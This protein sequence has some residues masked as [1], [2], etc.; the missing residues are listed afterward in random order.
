LLDVSTT[1]SL[2]VDSNGI[3]KGNTGICRDIT[4][5]KKA[6]GTLKAK[7][8][9][10][11]SFVESNPDAILVFDLQG[12]VIR[13]NKAFEQMFGWTKEEI[14]GLGLYELPIIP[15]GYMDEVKCL[16]A[17]AKKGN[18]LLERETI[19]ITKDETILN[20]MLFI[21]PIYDE[22]GSI[23]EWSVTIRDLSEWKK[24][25]QMLQNTE[26]L[27]VAGQL[28]AGIAHEIRNP[29]T[30]IKGFVQLMKSGL[31]EKKEYFDIML[32][33]IERIEQILSELL[34]LAKPHVSKFERKDSELP[35][36]YANA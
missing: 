6:E 31:N 11:E 8:H 29:I 13:V 33:E 34:L 22:K 1:N 12:I 23:H 3:V 14:I 4:P 21:S 30:A 9:Q 16:E 35:A 5:R 17:E 10:Q 7:T 18:F 24:S 15:S 28:A 25:Q 36:T 26:K 27:S 2:T 32:S 20:V 19:Y